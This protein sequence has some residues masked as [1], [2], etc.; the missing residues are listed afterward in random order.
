MRPEARC[1]P[2]CERDPLYDLDMADPLADDVAGYGVRL[3]DEQIAQFDSYLGL[4]QEWSS[5]ANL[6]SDSSADVV[7]QRHFAES[8][9]LGAAMREREIMRP[10]VRMI[11][12]GAGAGFPGLPIR[13]AWPATKL[14]YKR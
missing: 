4:L 13:I 3:S 2:V 9:A 14:T 10:G 5:R 6:V 12:I 11:D 8:I 1:N 7:R